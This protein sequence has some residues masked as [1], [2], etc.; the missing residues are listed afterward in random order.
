MGGTNA[1][2]SAPE[3]AAGLI[4]VLDAAGPDMAGRFV[5]YLGAEIAW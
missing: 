3:S 2:V 1:A 5:D 4:K